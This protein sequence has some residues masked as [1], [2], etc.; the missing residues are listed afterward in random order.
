[1]PIPTRRRNADIKKLLRLA[2]RDDLDL[3]FEDE[4]R[5][6]QHGSR[7]R[8][9]VPP[10]EVDPF[11][12]HA[13]TRRSVGAF[14]AV[15]PDD[16]PFVASRAECFDAGTFPAFLKCLLR[17]KRRARMILV[18]LDNARWH[19]VKMI[20]PWLKEYKRALRLD[21]LPA[22]SPDLN[23]VERVWKL[24]R[25]ICTHNRYFESLD[26]LVETVFGQFAAWRKPNDTLRRLCAVI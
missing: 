9:W 24:T 13:P 12:L 20:L 15:R 1:M 17:H 16:G 22:Y 23:C 6:Q 19:H 11:V 4:C 26:D 8:M 18:I 10:E 2:A 7:C 21:F 14:G 25:R 3:R 5:F